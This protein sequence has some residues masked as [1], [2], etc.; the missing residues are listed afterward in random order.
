M[1]L[2]N[3]AFSTALT[4]SGVSLLACGHTATGKHARHA[5]GLEARFTAEVARAASRMSREEAN[6]LLKRLIPIYEPDL[7][8]E[9]IGKPFEEV[10]D[11]DRLEPTPKWQGTYDDVRD[12]L[13]KLEL[14]LGS[15][16]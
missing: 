5:S 6:A 13:T 14:P 2:E 12:E 11:L 15:L 9:P 8:S 16:V 3:A 4:V 7:E 1:L 10:Y